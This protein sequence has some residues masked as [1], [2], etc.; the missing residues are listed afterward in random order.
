MSFRYS[1]IDTET[2]GLKASSNKIIEIAIINMDGSEVVEKYETLINPLRPISSWISNIT[3]L[4]NEVLSKAPPFHKV[5]RKIVE[6]TQGRTFVAHN[7]RFDYEFL[8]HE[9]SE[10]SYTFNPNTH[11]TVRLAR[12]AF[13]KLGSYS[14]PKLTSELG[15]E[16][17][18][19]HRAMGDAEATA[20]LFKMILNKLGNSLETQ[21][22]SASI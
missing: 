17:N 10:L 2:T 6:M 14:L 18:S 12:K 19:K 5:A 4:D 21:R 7:A 22:P 15:I 8:K 20:S 9:F 1:I 11:C 3:G 16:H 13:P